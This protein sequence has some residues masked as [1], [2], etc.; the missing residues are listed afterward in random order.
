MRVIAFAPARTLER[1]A[2]LLGRE[3]IEV[4]G[5]PER[6][7][8]MLPLRERD[9]FDLALLDSR[10][11]NAETAWQCMRE[12]WDVPLVLMVGKG[13]LDWRRLQSLGADAYLPDA[14]N[15]GEFIARLKAILRRLSLAR[16]AAKVQSAL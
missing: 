1:L 15:N 12:L 16:G 9:G 5:T 3:G 11:E 10:A 8:Q 7:E 6:I 2:I 4:M 13:P 14:A